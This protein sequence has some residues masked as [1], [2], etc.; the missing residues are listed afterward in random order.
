VSEANETGKKILGKQTPEPYNG[1]FK[2]MDELY[3]RLVNMWYEYVLSY[4]GKEYFLSWYREDTTNIF[5]IGRTWLDE[6][7]FQYDTFDEMLDNFKENGKSLRE[8][9]SEAEIEELRHK[10]VTKKTS[11]DITYNGNVYF[12]CRYP[13]KGKLIFVIGYAED[14]Y[15]YNYSGNLFEYDSFDG[16]LDNFKVDGKSLR[17]FI[18]DAD[19]EVNEYSGSVEEYV[20]QVLWQRRHKKEGDQ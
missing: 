13:R 15:D 1:K 6:D 10:L 12:L 19:V 8:F 9:L 14:W 2:N 17:E 18:F 4:K 7:P 16:L 5:S 20:N 11:S 3:D